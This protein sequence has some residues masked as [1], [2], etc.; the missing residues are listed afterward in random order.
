MIPTQEGAGEYLICNRPPIRFSWSKG[1][2]CTLCHVVL[3]PPLQNV[4]LFKSSSMGQTQNKQNKHPSPPHT[5][6]RRTVK[7]TENQKN[8]HGITY[9]AISRGKPLDLGRPNFLTY[10]PTSP[11]K[12]RKEK[13]TTYSSLMC[14]WHR[15][16]L[17]G[18]SNVNARSTCPSS[19]LLQTLLVAV[20]ACS[21]ASS[22]MVLRPPGSLLDGVRARR[23]RRPRSHLEALFC[24]WPP[25]ALLRWC[26]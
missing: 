25:Q 16:S 10:K 21:F 23:Q 26:R 9:R 13:H 24:N 17:I 7:Q 2:F 14:S 19:S 15:E 18:S 22:A 8:Q 3:H 4:P 5:V 20:R 12:L 11:H 1:P 6:Q